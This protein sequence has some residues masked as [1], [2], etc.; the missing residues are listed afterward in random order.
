MEN[1]Q[2]LNRCAYLYENK[3]MRNVNIRAMC[4]FSNTL[5]VKNLQTEVNRDCYRTANRTAIAV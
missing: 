3:T 1:T 5:S 2:L 4:Q